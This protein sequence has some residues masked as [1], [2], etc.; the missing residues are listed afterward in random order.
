VWP[1]C[2][3]AWHCATELRL[4]VLWLQV[5]PSAYGQVRSP[6]FFLQRSYWQSGSQPGSSDCTAQQSQA[7]DAT[8]DSPSPPYIQIAGLR[9]VFPGPGGGQRVAVDDLSLGMSAGRISAL[10][11]HNGENCSGGALAGGGGPAVASNHWSINSTRVCCSSVV[12][13]VL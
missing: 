8:H 2:W 5:M 9:K 13:V 4:P 1:P 6:W 11:G 12:L 3:S 7:A 10:L